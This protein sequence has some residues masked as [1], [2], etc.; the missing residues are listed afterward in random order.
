M[1]ADCDAFS[2]ERLQDIALAGWLDATTTTAAEQ[3]RVILESYRPMLD[4]GDMVSTLQPF[5]DDKTLRDSYVPVEDL[6][7]GE[8]L[9]GLAA[10]QVVPMERFA[11][12][13]AAIA[14]IEMREIVAAVQ[15]AADG[16]FKS[17]GPALQ[18]VQDGTVPEG[19]PAVYE[20]AEALLVDHI[21]NNAKEIDGDGDEV[22]FDR[23]A[24]EAAGARNA[25][26]GRRATH[27]GI[28]SGVAHH[29]SARGG[30]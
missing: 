10:R 12:P 26:R 19:N 17:L 11:E 27:R 30:S 22:A 29:Q 20:T 15:R 7:Q 9:E 5:Y 14:D 3:D 28:G 18:A 2:V 23:A 1:A 24:F 4:V 16:Q 25:Y 21:A 8:R 6:S 13:D